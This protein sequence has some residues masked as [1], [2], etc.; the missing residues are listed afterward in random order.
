MPLDNSR[1]LFIEAVTTPRLCGY[2]ETW[3]RAR[4]CS[5]LDIASTFFVRCMYD[6]FREIRFP[7]FF[8]AESI[9]SAFVADAIGRIEGWSCSE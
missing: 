2:V 6:I 1:L 4:T 9:T 8:N 3:A 5:T 7:D